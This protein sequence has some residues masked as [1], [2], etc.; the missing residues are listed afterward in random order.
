M[1]NFIQT[2]VTQPNGLKDLKVGG[3]FAPYSN[4]SIDYN[5]SR[6][7]RFDVS[8]PFVN[9]KISNGKYSF[10]F[11]NSIISKDFVQEKHFYNKPELFEKLV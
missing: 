2:P 7:E 4:T 1:S 8:L 3:S 11:M 5:T 9:A 6:I 10:L